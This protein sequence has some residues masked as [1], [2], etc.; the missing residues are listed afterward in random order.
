[1]G[2]FEVLQVLVCMHVLYE[3]Y[4]KDFEKLL[5][6]GFLAQ[7]THNCSVLLPSAE[8]RKMTFNWVYQPNARKIKKTVI[9]CL[10]K[11]RS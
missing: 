7:K 5:F 4:T 1:M 2:N 11:S 9:T 10:T 8:K 3:E 6:F